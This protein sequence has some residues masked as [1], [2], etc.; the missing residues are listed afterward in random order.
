VDCPDRGYP[1]GEFGFHVTVDINN[2]PALERLALC[3]QYLSD[4]YLHDPIL[5]YSPFP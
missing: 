2:S 3:I 4:W 1:R 5:I